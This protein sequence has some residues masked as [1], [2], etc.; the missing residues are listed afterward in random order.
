[1]HNVRICAGT[2]SL[3][4]LF[5]LPAC[6]L[7]T[8]SNPKY[9][10]TE[11]PDEWLAQVRVVR[12]SEPVDGLIELWDVRLT[13]VQRKWQ[14]QLNRQELSF[15]QVRHNTVTLTNDTTKSA[16]GIWTLTVGR[17]ERLYFSRRRVREQDLTRYHSLIA[18]LFFG[19]TSPSSFTTDVMKPFLWGLSL[20]NEWLAARTT[21]PHY[22]EI[23]YDRPPNPFGCSHETPSTIRRAV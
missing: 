10:Y 4:S 12:T 20:R 16:C 1:M 14:F 21:V 6:S 11:S 9:Y 7:A 5:L 13:K 3:V 15:R 22:L 2:I 18:K 23:Y 8:A 19:R 17:H